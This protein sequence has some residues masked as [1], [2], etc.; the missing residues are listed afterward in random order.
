MPEKQPSTPM[1]ANPI[2]SF[3]LK[4]AD[5]EPINPIETKIPRAEQ[6]LATPELQAELQDPRLLT[7]PETG[8]SFELLEL[9]RHVD[10][11]PLVMTLSWSIDSQHP[12][13]NY[14]A[15]QTALQTGRRMLVVNNPNT[16]HGDKLT[17]EQRHALKSGE[18]FDT[19]AK[20]LLS[21]FRAHNIN[22]IDLDG[23]SMGGRLAAS[24]A[25]NA[26]SYGIEVGHLVLIDP[27]GMSDRGLVKLTRDFVSENPNL[28]RYNELT[29]DPRYS[30]SDSLLD[31]MKFFVT[32]A[33]QGFDANFISYTK[34]MAKG[35]L[36]TDIMTA[37][38][39]QPDLLVTWI[40]GDASHISNP[41]EVMRTYHLLPKNLQ[42]RVRLQILPGETH[43]LGNG[44]AKR[45]AAHV[46]DALELNKETI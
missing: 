40:Y 38:G 19:V 5:F 28:A 9:N 31:T 24:L 42:R 29:R 37:L 35:N 2:A 18:G 34:A 26:S 16:G 27:P 3:N 44:Q 13:T 41:S 6:L 46:K 32:L 1:D 7:D 21:A 8:Q 33:R 12:G 15:E 23:T 11:P 20:P 14:E 39:S 36:V 45:I 17:R 43:A 22:Q 10:G 4:T 25:A 30:G